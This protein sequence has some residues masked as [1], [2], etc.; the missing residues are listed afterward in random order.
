MRPSRWWSGAPTAPAPTRWPSLLP[1]AEPP[2]CLFFI[3]CFAEP[4]KSP[5]YFPEFLA[6]MG[7][8]LNFFPPVDS[9]SNTRELIRTWFLPPG[10]FVNIEWFVPKPIFSQ[11]QTRQ[12]WGGKNRS[13][14]RICS[15]MN[16]GYESIEQVTERSRCTDHDDVLH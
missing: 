14:D 2:T 7:I 6:P 15:R 12:I 11:T 16:R 8:M 1:P 10:D 9:L 4:P 3:G 5:S 13:L